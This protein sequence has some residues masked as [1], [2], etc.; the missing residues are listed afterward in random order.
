MGKSRTDR[1]GLTREQK[2]IKE[3]KAL[4]REIQKLRK[5]LARNELNRYENVKEAVEDH[6]RNLG[7]PT[8]QDLLESLKREW[9]CKECNEGYLEIFLYN[10]LD[11]TW[12]Y[13]TCSNAPT[14]NNRTKAQK[15]DPKE[16]K[17]I[18]KKS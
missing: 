12:Y 17:G 5:A 18:I 11:Q 14:C 3:N 10:K 8:T 15:Y 6:E 9:A 16:V 13:R 1:D 2:L 4:K 7:L